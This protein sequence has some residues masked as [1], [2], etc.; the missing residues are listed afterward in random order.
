MAGIKCGLALVQEL[1]DSFVLFC[2]KTPKRN[3]NGGHSSSFRRSGGLPVVFEILREFICP[4]ALPVT[5]NDNHCRWR[6][7]CGSTDA[8]EGRSRPDTEP[9]LPGRPSPAVTTPTAGAA[10]RRTRN[11]GALPPGKIATPRRKRSVSSYHTTSGPAALAARSRLSCSDL[12][13][14][15]KVGLATSGAR[16]IRQG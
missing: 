12:R 3:P 5:H 4:S 7:C 9:S 14:G 11:P 15:N 13:R 16:R 2:I 6:R 10:P 8:L 1:A